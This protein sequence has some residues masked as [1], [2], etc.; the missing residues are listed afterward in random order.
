MPFN[1]MKRLENLENSLIFF[2]K[3]VCCHKGSK[4]RIYDIKTGKRTFLLRG[5]KNLVH[6]ILYDENLLIST[7]KDTQ[8]LLWVNLFKSILLTSHRIPGWAMKY[9]VLY[10]GTRVL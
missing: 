10:Q 8:V 7:S 1:S 5:H 2:K 6:S 3:I 4:I 9:V